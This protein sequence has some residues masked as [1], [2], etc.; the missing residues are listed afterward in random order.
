[1]D[2][3]KEIWVVSADWKFRA[4]VRAEL[5]E[6]GYE[7]HGYE[8][9]DAAAAEL[10]AGRIPAVLVVDI[11]EEGAEAIA[12]SLARWAAHASV[13]LVAGGTGGE[14]EVP[15]G[16]VVLRRP[17]KVEDVVAAAVAGAGAAAYVGGRGGW[18]W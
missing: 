12:R 15:P 17:L 16:V 4:L 2:A 10:G 6:R 13:V 11:S 7:A 9:L 1:M 14:L 18:K 3:V 8:N 5:R